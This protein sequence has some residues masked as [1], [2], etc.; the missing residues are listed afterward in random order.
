MTDKRQSPPDRLTGLPPVVS[1]GTRV[2]VLGS[3]PG[4]ASLRM[5]QI[6]YPTPGYVSVFF[7]AGSQ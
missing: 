2:L 6:N 7:C 5:Q 4:A 1:P 3:F